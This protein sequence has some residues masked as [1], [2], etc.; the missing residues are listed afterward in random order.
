MLSFVVNSLDFKSTGAKILTVIQT[1]TSI[2]YQW[3]SDDAY[4]FKGVHAP[5]QN[6]PD[7]NYD[8]AK[9]YDV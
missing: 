4:Q 7:C 5:G 6:V 3:I 9:L 1:V 8:D 2:S